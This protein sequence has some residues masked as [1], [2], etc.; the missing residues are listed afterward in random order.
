MTRKYNRLR[1]RIVEKYGSIA[2]FAE[3]T[4]LSGQQIYYKLSERS[5]ISATDIRL[6]AEIL[7]ITPEEIGKYFF[8]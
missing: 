1:G 7:E 2:A 3:K 6:W 5:G 8:E 4:G